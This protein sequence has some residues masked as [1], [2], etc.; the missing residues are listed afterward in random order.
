MAD[1]V[2]KK[3]NETYVKVECDEGIKAELNDFFSFFAHNYQFSPLYRKR[4][5]NGKVYLYSRKKSQLYVGLI[6]HL[7]EFC[8]ERKL[9]IEIDPSAQQL[10]PC[11][12]EEVRA[13]SASLDLHSRG[14][15]IELRD[16][17]VKGFVE[18][19]QRKR[20]LVLSPTSC[21]YPETEAECEISD[22][23]NLFLNKNYS[24]IRSEEHTSELQSH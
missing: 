6:Y 7:R 16:Y 1:V 18:A 9:T 10:S 19:V 11:T 24:K 20:C 21:L 23:A 14:N 3:I 22:E 13:F 4:I 2:V 17:Q 15:P 8:K 12:M 5:W